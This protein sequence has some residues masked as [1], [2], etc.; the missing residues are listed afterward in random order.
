MDFTFSLPA[1]DCYAGQTVAVLGLGRSGIAAARLLKRHGAQVTALDSGN[2]PAL[3]ESGQMLENEGIA[4]AL[5][6]AAVDLETAFDWA[7]LSPGIDPVV[8]MITEFHRRRPGIQVIG[9][10]ELGYRHCAAPI[11]AITGTNGKTTTTELTTE[12]LLAA[13]RRAVAAG[14][15][16]TPLSEIA[17][18]T[19]NLDWVVVE[20]SSFQLETITSFRPRI[21]AWT[22]FTADHLDRYPNMGEYREAKEH[23]WDYMRPEDLALIPLGESFP[24][25]NSRVI[26]HSVSKPGA[27]YG[28]ENGW[29]TRRG[30]PVLDLDTV[31]LVGLHNA[32][33]MAVAFALCEA[34]G[35]TP[36]EI[37]P[38]LQAYKPRP[39]RCEKIRERG[40]VLW[41]NDSKATNLDSLEKALL[42]QTRPVV[43][44]AGG[45]DKGFEYE[46]LAGL[47]A[48]KVRDT[49]LLGE[50]KERIA[51]VW[52]DLT[53]GPA[54][55]YLADTLA[56]AVEAARE[57]SRPGDVV[58]FS[59]GT[60]SFDMFTSYVDRGNQFRAL[61]QALPDTEEI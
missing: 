31:Q 7:V 41:L 56:A 53:G 23:I 16:G 10:M 26:T 13:G 1:V 22:N 44:I 60:S 48:A 35:L 46:R 28:L 50:M 32:E 36:A 5:G 47:V 54:E 43:L 21:A 25:L 52:P 55:H 61:V 4:T 15:I 17:E 51:H 24:S 49:V 29:I 34:C 57:F 38:A 33:N 8:P 2:S 19:P 18:T 58:L 20:V 59:P 6:Q 42:S 12:V 45:K 14:N 39:H 9:E 37:I 30:E 3:A 40:G 11:V 27:D